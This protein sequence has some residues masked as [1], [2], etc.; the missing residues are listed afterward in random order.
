MSIGP[1]TRWHSLEQDQQL[2][3]DL[4]HLY[5]VFDASP[6]VRSRISV[7]DFDG[8]QKT[9]S[10][11]YIVVDYDDNGESESD[12]AAMLP[13]SSKQV[14]TCIMIVEDI[15]SNLIKDLTNLLDI[16][17]EVFEDHLLDG[18]WDNSTSVNDHCLF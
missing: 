14:S 10:Q 18:G 16:S 5:N 13:L 6:D 7:Y 9:I 1:L 17:L 4:P 15:S 2:R 8:D 12:V 11:R 3:I